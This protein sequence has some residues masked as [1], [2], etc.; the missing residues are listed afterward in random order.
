MQGHRGRRGAIGI[1]SNPYLSQIERGLREPSEKVLD[2]IARSLELSAEGLCEQG[3]RR[4][5]EDEDDT[6]VPAV[7]A[8]HP[9]PEIAALRGRDAGE[10]ASR[11]RALR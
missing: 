10:E 9:A 1:G 11:P 4:R 8:E 3:G 6:E 2:A 5:G 7:V